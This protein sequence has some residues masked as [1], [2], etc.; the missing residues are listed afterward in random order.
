MLFL[1]EADATAHPAFAAASPVASP[2]GNLSTQPDIRQ[3][4]YTCLYNHT[5]Y[6][7]STQST[8]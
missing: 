8:E 3:K 1:I 6:S 7:D 2:T 5:F 4:Q